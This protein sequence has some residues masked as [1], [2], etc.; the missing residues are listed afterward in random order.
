MS[1]NNQKQ[2]M[3]L[4]IREQQEQ[5]EQINRLE[6]MNHRLIARLNSMTFKQYAVAMCCIHEQIQLG[7]LSESLAGELMLAL[8]DAW[9]FSYEEAHEHP[10]PQPEP[11]ASPSYN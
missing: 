3:K 2:R 1:K 10:H 4:R 7:D 9:D 8:T 6:A 11:G 5:Q